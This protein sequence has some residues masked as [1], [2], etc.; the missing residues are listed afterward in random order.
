MHALSTDINI[1]LYHNTVHINSYRCGLG[2]HI[3]AWRRTNISSQ[4]RTYVW[5][6]QCLIWGLGHFVSSRRFVQVHCAVCITSV[7]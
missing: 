7:H 5:E 2:L 6:S 3:S 4:S 1:I